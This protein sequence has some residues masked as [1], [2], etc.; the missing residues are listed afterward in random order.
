M[1]SSQTSD[2]LLV[3]VV[4]GFYGRP[5]TVQQ[6]ERLFQNL[7]TWSLNSYVY[8]PKDDLK[9][10]ASWRSLY[11]KHELQ[12]LG[13]LVKQCREAGIRFVYAMGP[14]LDIHYASSADRKALSD[15]VGQLQ[16][17]GVADFALLF[18]DIPDGMDA[19]DR[20]RF[21]SFAAAQ[22]EVSNALLA[23]CRE[24]SPE[25][26]FLFCPTPYCGRMRR[27][28]LGGEG[29]LEMLGER[30]DPSIRIFWTGPEIISREITESH[31]R[32]LADCLKRPVLIWDNYHANDYD[33]RRL[34][35][36]PLEGRP[37][38]ENNLLS[39]ILLNPNCEFE[40]NF[41]PL[42]SL[43]RWA[44]DG[45]QYAAESVFAEGLRAWSAE[46]DGVGDPWTAEEL[47]LFAAI[48]YSPFALGQSA[49]EMFE[50]VARLTKSDPEDWGDGW[51]RFQHWRQ[52]TQTISVKLTELN[53]RD[54]FYTFNRQ[55]WEIREEFDLLARFL[56]YRREHGGQARLPGS[57]EHLP[58]TYRGGL[59]RQLQR[60]LEMG[61]DGGFS[62]S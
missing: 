12:A 33:L 41:V 10:R 59:I 37:S 19:A 28:G 48:F 8:A 43:G 4:E 55:W 20:E 2:R 58:G 11:D 15:R 1:M 42:Y 30:L 36:G 40:A 17:L 16:D 22:A 39:G 24:F 23:E 6:R 50:E 61:S 26:E 49:A 18:D 60:L 54:L 56:A 13:V 34:Y 5:W 25:S 44:A 7:A 3:G 52:L 35:T 14:G 27:E 21:G 57:P 9:H 46:F 51:D 38:S 62:A 29:Y 32:E 31:L 47:A 53:N 45:D